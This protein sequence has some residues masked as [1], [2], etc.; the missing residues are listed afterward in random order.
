MEE[1]DENGEWHEP[2][3]WSAN[4]DVQKTVLTLAAIWL[5]AL[6]FAYLTTCFG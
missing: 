4:G 2:V 6:V 3:D 5:A 1:R